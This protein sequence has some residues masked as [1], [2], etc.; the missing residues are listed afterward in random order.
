MTVFTHFFF[1]P[2]YI[3]MFAIFF[4]GGALC[5]LLLIGSD[6]DNLP[7]WKIYIG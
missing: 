3:L 1:W 4:G 2:R 6:L 5:G 7:K